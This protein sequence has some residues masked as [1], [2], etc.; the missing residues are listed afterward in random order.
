MNPYLSLSLCALCGALCAASPILTASTFALCLFG[1]SWRFSWKVVGACVLVFGVSAFRAE[2]QVDAYRTVHTQTRTQFAALKRCVVSATVRTSPMLR[3]DALGFIAEL[4]TGEC[5]GTPLQSGS[6]VR[7]YGG[8][9]SLARGD[10]F[11][12]IV[13]LAVVGIFRNEDLGDPYVSYSRG[14]VTLSGSVLAL[15]HEA[16]GT[17]LFSHIDRLRAHVRARIESTFAPAAVGMAKALVLGEN[18]LTEEEDQAFK[19][20]GLAHLLAVSGTHLVFAVVSLVEALRQVLVRIHTLAAGRNM[21]RWAA[22]V[23]IPL[24]LLYAD[25]AGGSGSAW[26]AAWMLAAAFLVRCLGRELV[27]SRAVATSLWV[28]WL[29]DPLAVF[30]LSFMLSL[31]ATSGLLTVGRL[32]GHWADYFSHRGAKLVVTGVVATVSSMLPCALFLAMLSPNISLI[33]IVA[34]VFAAP[35]GE[36]IALPLCLSHALMSPWPAL[37]RGTALVGSGALLVVKQVAFLSDRF[38]FIGLSVPNPSAAQIAVICA[39]TALFVALGKRCFPFVKRVQWRWLLATCAALVLVVL[40]TRARA[41]GSPTGI[42]RVTLLDVGQGDSALVDLP[43]GRLMLIDAGGFVGSPID[44]G[45]RVVLPVLRARR[46][47]HI[48]IMVL[49]HPHPDHFGGLLSVAETL[50]VTEFWD[51]GQGEQEGA[52]PEYRQL[53]KTLRGRGTQIK[54]PAELC[55]PTEEVLGGALLR[56]LGPC[57]RAVPG[58]N[59]NDN[60]LVLRLRYGERSVLFTGDAE[61]EQEQELLTSERSALRADVL[62]VGHHGSRTSTSPAFLGAVNPALATISCGMRNSYGH[63]HAVTLDTLTHGKV[64]YARLDDTGSVRVSTDGKNL[65]LS[66]FHGVR[67]LS[68][69]SRQDPGAVH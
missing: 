13:Q 38:S 31:A 32:W 29:Y 28:G 34:N 50:P 54:R 61:Q 68:E 25:F 60:S 22:G 1:Y 10:R 45:K 35:F 2:A 65:N 39:G 44:P 5:E 8:P 67:S 12:G 21:G 14:G 64:P 37:E 19:G 59:A 66:T 3:G 51:T 40:E 55:R 42:L 24:A 48:D 58:R 56:V 7:L 23:G 4:H 57:P 6:R 53:L 18:D 46:R 33:G 52:G 62:K 43:D 36:V 9:T 15:E 63:P 26:R 49:S 27:A 30:D 16:L 20:S 69:F 41:F 17:S 47:A 11:E